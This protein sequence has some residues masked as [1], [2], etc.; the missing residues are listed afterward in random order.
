MKKSIIA[1]AA[2]VLAALAVVLAGCAQ[3]GI[4]SPGDVLGSQPTTGKLEVRVTDAPPQK[5]ITA[6]NVTVASVEINKSGTAE[7]DGGWMTL[8]FAGPATFDLLKV[9]DREQLLAVKDQLEPGKYGQIRMEVTR[10]QVTFDNN[11]TPEVV[12]AKLPSGK[13]KFIKGFEIAAGQTTVLLFDFIASESIHTAG[14]SGQVI[15]QPV[16]K[17]SVTQVPGAMEITTPGL[18]NGMAGQPY[19]APMAAMG[20]TAPY[21]WSIATGALPAGLAIDAATGAITGTPSAAGLSTFRVRV[22]D[23]SADAKKAAE[24]VFTIDIAAAGTIQ[25]VE[26]SLAEGT[27][28]VAY[29]AQLNALGGTATRTWAVTSGTLPAGLVIDATT[30]IISG[31][32]SAAGETSITVTVTDTTAPTPLTDSQAFLLRVVAAPAPPPTT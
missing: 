18:P 4:P 24:R 29:S 20:G 7:A 30:G 3:L 26:T 17:L 6:V 10:V 13:L 19:T 5:V 28:G 9:Q 32:P 2:G 16:I 12:D 23:S 14:N 1:K 31:T 11:G 8:D 15:F 25:I 21:T 27:V 22:V